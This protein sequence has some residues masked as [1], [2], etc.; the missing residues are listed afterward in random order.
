[1]QAP[2]TNNEKSLHLLANTYKAQ[3]TEKMHNIQMPDQMCEHVLAR[4]HKRKRLEGL[5]PGGCDK[6]AH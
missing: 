3:S 1:M 6:H 2:P 4:L 5:M